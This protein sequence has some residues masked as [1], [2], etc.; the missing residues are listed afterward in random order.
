MF[1]RTL[2]YFKCDGKISPFYHTQTKQSCEASLSRDSLHARQENLPALRWHYLL[3]WQAN[4]GSWKYQIFDILSS[5]QSRVQLL[6]YNVKGYTQF[7]QKNCEVNHYILFSH[8]KLSKHSDSNK[9]ISYFHA[10]FSYL[11]SLW[12]FLCM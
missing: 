11:N 6:V 2:F 8:W 7:G 3:W 9:P 1:F 10:Q 5:S 12:V 4:Q